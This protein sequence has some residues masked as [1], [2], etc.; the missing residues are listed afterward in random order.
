MA[1]F[2]LG[3]SSTSVVVQY[4]KTQFIMSLEAIKISFEE[5]KNLSNRAICRSL[6]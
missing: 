1:S 2:H 6:N 3:Q 4:N 5:A